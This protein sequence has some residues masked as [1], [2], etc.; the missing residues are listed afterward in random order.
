MKHREKYKLAGEMAGSARDWFEPPKE[1]SIGCIG[2][3]EPELKTLW[4]PKL[5]I[6]SLNSVKYLSIVVPHFVFT[7][8][9]P[10]L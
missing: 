3:S 9:K 6:T 2:G 7:E 10:H 1:S 5:K 8:L 4:G